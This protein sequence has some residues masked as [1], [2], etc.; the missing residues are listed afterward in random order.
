VRGD[1]FEQVKRLPARYL[2]GIAI[3]VSLVVGALGGNPSSADLVF[4][5]F[6]DFKLAV[7][8]ADDHSPLF[9]PMLSSHGNRTF[10]VHEPGKIGSHDRFE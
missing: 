6:E 9:I 1:L 10:S 4:G 2:I 7:A 5:K 8:D 3:G